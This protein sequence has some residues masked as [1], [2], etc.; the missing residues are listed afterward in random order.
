MMSHVKDHPL[1]KFS[2]GTGGELVVFIYQQACN[3]LYYEQQV[4]VAL[5]TGLCNINW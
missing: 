3:L 5:Y 1:R 2:P 4:C